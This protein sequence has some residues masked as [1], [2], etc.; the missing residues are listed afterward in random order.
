MFFVRLIAELG[1][2]IAGF[3]EERDAALEFGEERVVA[4]N[5]DGGR[6]TEVFLEHA[7]EVAVEVPVFDAVVVA[8]ADEEILVAR[9]V[10]D[11]VAGFEFSVFFAWA[12]EGFYEFAVFIELED[13]IGAVAIGDEYRAVGRDGDGAGI[14]AFVVFKEVRFFWVVERPDVFASEGEFDD[15]VLGGAGGVNEFGAVF[16]PDFKG[17]DVAGADRTEEFAGGIVNENAARGVGGD[18]DISCL[19]DDSSAVAGADGRAAGCGFEV[20]GDVVEFKLNRVRS[21]DRDGGEKCTC[22]GWNAGALFGGEHNAIVCG[23]AIDDKPEDSERNS[24]MRE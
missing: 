8:I 16:V 20:V 9:I 6:H 21:V 13:V 5:V 15:F 11:A 2:D 3:V 22:D 10:G 14:K 19:V 24:E 12:A 18:V 7:N 17:V 4:A 23:K 1:G